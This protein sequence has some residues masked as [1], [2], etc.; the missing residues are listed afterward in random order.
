MVEGVVRM[1]WHAQLESELAMNNKAI[2]QI[3]GR[4]WTVK[5]NEQG[6]VRFTSDYGREESFASVKELENAVASWY[7]SPMIRVQ[8]I[9]E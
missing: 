1:D 4:E 5:Q 6:H 2:L 7:E 8:D 9:R 3:D